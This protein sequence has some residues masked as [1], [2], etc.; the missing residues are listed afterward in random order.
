MKGS[1]SLGARG[2]ALAAALVA[3]A[4]GCASA[5]AA[6]T[7]P[8]GPPLAVPEAPPRVVTAPTVESAEASVPEVV[9]VEPAPAPEPVPTTEAAPPAPRPAAASAAEAEPPP[10]RNLR[11][12]GGAGDDAALASIRTQLRRT[13]RE[14]E[15]VDYNALTGPGRLQYEQSRRFAQQAETALRDRNLA[16]A[17]TL[18]EKAAALAAGLSGG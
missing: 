1:R 8:A 16:Y 4:A 5:Q 17:A 9:V 13:A 14:L 18:A 2:W 7:V 15:A 3:G 10:I 11:A 12:G 6:G